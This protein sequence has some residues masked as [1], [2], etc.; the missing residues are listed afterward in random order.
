M[1]VKQFWDLLTDG[2]YR[3]PHDLFL[4][5]APVPLA[6]SRPSATS[7][8]PSD[9]LSPQEIRRMDRVAQFAVASTREA[10]ADSGLDARRRDRRAHRRGMGSAVGCTISLEKRVR[11]GQRRRPRLARRPR[12]RGPRTSTEYFVPSSMAAEVGRRPAREGPAAVVSTG[13]TSGIDAVG[14][15]C[16][17]IQRGRRRRDDRRRDRRA[18]LPD[19]ARLLRRHQGHHARATTSPERACRPF[20]RTRNGFVLG[21]GAAVLVLEELEQRARAA[22]RTSTPRS[23]ASPRAATRST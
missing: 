4:R 13:C 6:R 18:D 7:T 21:E 1:G 16:E 11:G 23:P 15:A 19:H 3:D 5:P 8:R 10:L 9:G 12:V 14:H 2:P 22:A 17:L 20:D